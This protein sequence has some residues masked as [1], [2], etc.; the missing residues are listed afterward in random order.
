MSYDVSVTDD[1]LSA[2][3]QE[4]P[5]RPVPGLGLLHEGRFSTAI[6]VDDLSADLRRHRLAD[7]AGR[8]AVLAIG[9]N[10]CAAVVL[11]KLASVGVDATVPFLSGSAPGISVGHSAHRSVAGFIPAAPYATVSTRNTFIVNMFNGDQ[12][13][14]IDV[15]E[16]NYR[17]ITVECDLPGRGSAELYVSRWGVIAPPEGPVLSL[18]SQT[19]LFR[20]LSEQCQGFRE[21]QVDIKPRTVADLFIERGWARDP[22]LG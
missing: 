11:R 14:A 13:A 20:R 5:G 16:P 19:A 8:T 21:A 10:A 22:G 9:S 7:L 6:D 17:R 2:R 15:T 12:L 18:M 4:Y 1:N 3:P